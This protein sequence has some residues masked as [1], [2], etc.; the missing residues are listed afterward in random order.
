VLGGGTLRVGQRVDA[1]ARLGAVPYEYRDQY[2]DG[3][4]VYYRADNR[5]IYQIDSRNDVV[6]RIYPMRR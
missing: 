4:G 3:N 6:L 1:N 2:R 5:A